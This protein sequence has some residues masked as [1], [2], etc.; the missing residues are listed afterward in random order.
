M[1]GHSDGQATG[2]TSGELSKTK[3]LIFING[4]STFQLAALYLQIKG[5][6]NPLHR[7][8]LQL[9]LKYNVCA[10]HLLG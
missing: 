8:P 6:W 10:I 3:H 7:S 5:Y 4:G 1:S 9:Y 2:M